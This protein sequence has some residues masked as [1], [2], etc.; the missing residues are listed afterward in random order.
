MRRRWLLGV[1]ALALVGAAVVTWRVWPRDPG[2]VAPELTQRQIHVAEHGVQGKVTWL[3]GGS[4]TEAHELWARNH[5]RIGYEGVK[6]RLLGVSM[7]HVESDQ[8]TGDYWLVL[9]DRSYM[10]AFGPG[11]GGGYGYEMELYDHGLHAVSG[12]IYLT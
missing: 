4:R 8:L 12:R 5:D 7:V 1:V 3:G 6:P 9:F 10:W 11:G 2:S